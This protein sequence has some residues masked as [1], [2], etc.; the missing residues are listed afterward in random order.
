M[1]VRKAI[2][3]TNGA[4]RP[5]SVLINTLLQEGFH[6]TTSGVRPLLS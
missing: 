4:I 3:A 2:I 5:V 6:E 1:S